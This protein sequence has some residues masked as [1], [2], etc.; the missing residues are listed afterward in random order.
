MSDGD[1]APKW[2]KGYDIVK[3]FYG[4]AKTSA[5][6]IDLRNQAKLG[7]VTINTYYEQAKEEIN[8][9]LS[10]N[11]KNQSTVFG[12]MLKNHSAV[13]LGLRT[14]LKHKVYVYPTIKKRLLLF[15][16][17]SFWLIVRTAPYHLSTVYRF[18]GILLLSK[19]IIP[20]LEMHKKKLGM[21]FDRNVKELFKYRS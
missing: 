3:S 13:L 10:K 19:L 12:R 4:D 20:D 1:K 16:G 15:S 6:K 21:E 14:H 17:L 2:R 7:R 8:E 5:T 11:G 9:L 18:A